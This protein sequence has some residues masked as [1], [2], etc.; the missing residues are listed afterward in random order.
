MRTRCVIPTTSSRW[1]EH[2]SSFEADCQGPT[3]HTRCDATESPTGHRL[4]ATI[5]EPSRH[6][7]WV[8][9]GLVPDDHIGR[10]RLN[11]AH[12]VRRNRISY[13]P[14]ATGYDLRAVPSSQL[15]SVGACP[16]RPGFSLRS[17]RRTQGATQQNL[18]QATCYGPSLGTAVRNH[19]AERTRQTKSVSKHVPLPSHRRVPRYPSRESVYP[20]FLFKQA[21][22]EVC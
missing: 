22:S 1:M 21:Y 5:Y 8:A 6:C 15:R 20:P 2:P 19:Q 7:G 18:L 12:E 13:R 9:S 10:D 11:V 14:Q 3:S 17:E 4:R 16:R